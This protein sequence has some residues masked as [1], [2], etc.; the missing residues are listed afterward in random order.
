MAYNPHSPG[1]VE[2]FHKTI[3]YTLYYIYRDDPQNFDIKDNL[4]IVI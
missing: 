4:D 1:V 2:W 3:K